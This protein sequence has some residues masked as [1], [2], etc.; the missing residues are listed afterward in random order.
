MSQGS[1]AWLYIPEVTVD[2][3]SGFA[4][5]AKYINL[6][7]ISFTFEFMI[8]SPLQVYGSIWYFSGLTLL[9]FLFCLI[10]L[11]ET[12]GLNDLEKKTLYSPKGEDTW[13][14]LLEM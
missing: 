3:A 12:R 14:I 8:N 7:M 1:I 10:F 6:T 4:S 9:G 5:G 13:G 2:A 11:R